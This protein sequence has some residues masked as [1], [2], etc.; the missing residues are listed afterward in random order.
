MQFNWLEEKEYKT[1]SP[2]VQKWNVQKMDTVIGPRR[3]YTQAVAVQI[4]Y[5]L[6]L[7]ASIVFFQKPWKNFHFQ[8]EKMTHC[9]WKVQPPNLQAYLERHSI[10]Q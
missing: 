1:R 3:M 4:T 8:R 9:I 5:S 6:S 10:I 7:M 2:L